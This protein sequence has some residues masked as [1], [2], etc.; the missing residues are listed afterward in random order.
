[1]RR[2]V[3]LPPQAWVYAHLLA[4]GKLH[5]IPKPRLV[6]Q[7]PGLDSA[8]KPQPPA[9]QGVAQGHPLAVSPGLHQGVIG[10]GAAVGIID[11]IPTVP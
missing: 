11:A 1:M 9:E 2:R 4:A 3:P 5:H 8:G 10:G 6:L 7:L